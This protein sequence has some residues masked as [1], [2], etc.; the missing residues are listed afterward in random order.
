M[1][2]SYLKLIHLIAV[3]IFLGNIFTGLFWMHIAIK[4]KDIKIISHSI[5]G[6]IR[7]DRLFTIPG[8]ILITAGGLMTAIYGHIPIIHTGWIFWSL[9]LFSISGVAF[10]WKVAPLQK[11]IYQLTLNQE[12]PDNFNWTIFK[13]IYVAWEI[14]GLIALLTPVTAL[15][16]MT[17][18]FPQ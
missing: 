15:V 12:S 2:Y 17:L 7:S 4:T 8:V 1:T 6:V 14:W 3:I 18:K 13:K 11:K 10:A 9:I 16:M 5:K